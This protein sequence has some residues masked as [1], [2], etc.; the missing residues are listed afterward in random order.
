MAKD[1]GD[2]RCL[3]LH[4]IDGSLRADLQAVDR[5]LTP[6]VVVLGHRPNFQEASIEALLWQHQVDLTVAG[7]VHYTQRSCPLKAGACMTPNATG[8]YDG[9]VHVVAGNGGQALNNAS[10]SGAG[11]TVP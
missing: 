10:Q 2:C 4:D 11:A 9:I 8:G 1:S 7:H 5:A 6:W 3:G